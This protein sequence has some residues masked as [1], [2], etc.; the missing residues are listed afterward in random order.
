MQE[1]ARLQEG[2]MEFL[3]AALDGNST[4]T[5][6]PLPP[7]PAVVDPVIVADALKFLRR[8]NLPIEPRK[9]WPAGG[10]EHSDVRG[11]IN[12]PSELGRALGRWGDAGWGVLVKRGKY[13]DGRFD[14]QLVDACV[15]LINEWQP[16]P[17]PTWLTAIPSLAHPT[18]VSNFAER[19]A[20][21]LGLPFVPALV[22]T[23][24]RPAQKTMTNGSHQARNVDGALAIVGE[25]PDGPVLLVDDMVDSRWTLTVAAWLLRQQGS[26]PVFPLALARTGGDE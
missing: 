11:K 14:D 3:I 16:E 1:Y 8:S 21:A 20:A 9:N 13:S 23:E 4:P 5:E 17:R 7:L 2:H 18:L 15:R 24:A 25:V 6:P 12:P 22:K 26:G 10:L 19:L